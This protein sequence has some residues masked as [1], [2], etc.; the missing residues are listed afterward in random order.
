VRQEFW[1][2][3]PPASTL[4]QISALAPQGALVEVEATAVL[5]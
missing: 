5:D 1:P 2:T 3:D 4:V